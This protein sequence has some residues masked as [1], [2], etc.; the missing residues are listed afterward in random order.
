MELNQFLLAIQRNFFSGTSILFIFLSL[1]HSHFIIFYLFFC[2]RYSFQEPDAPDKLMA[3]RKN[4]AHAPLTVRA[5][6]EE[7]D[8]LLVF[9]VFSHDFE[10]HRAKAQQLREAGVF[11]RSST[12]S[13]NEHLNIYLAN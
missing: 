9:I 13:T 2:P 10:S 12:I 4:S 3:F 8:S 5:A 6:D 11:V 7:L 1:S